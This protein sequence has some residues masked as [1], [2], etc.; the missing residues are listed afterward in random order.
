MGLPAGHILFLPLTG[1]LCP[2]FNCHKLFLYK[3]P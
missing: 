1:T 3:E 2:D